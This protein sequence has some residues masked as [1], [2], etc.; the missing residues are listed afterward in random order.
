MYWK[1]QFFLD[2]GISLIATLAIF[3]AGDYFNLSL[4][5]ADYDYIREIA[6]TWMGPL[7]T[8]T[9]MMTATT[10]F[11]FTV[12]DRPEFE[13]IKGTVAES[14]L[15]TIFSENLFW[16]TFAIISCLIVTVS[17]DIIISSIYHLLPFGI[18]IISLCIAKFV[19]V[20]RQVL[21]VRIH[22]AKNN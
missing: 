12:I 5:Y 4:F 6:K 1:M 22:T 3:I 18:I 7:L 9:G 11:L 8:L 20:I 14:Q 2:I 19:W 15:W 13:K 10:A 17:N 21:S 16:M